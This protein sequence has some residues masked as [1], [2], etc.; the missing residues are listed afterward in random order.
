MVHI[1]LATEDEL[2]EEVA[3]ALAA[4]AGL[5]VGQTLRKRGFGYLQSNI[6]KFCELA[7]TFPV[8]LLTD[9][10]RRNCAPELVRT[11]IGRHHQP[12]NMLL[13][14][15]VREIESWLLAD[16][17]AMVELLG[18]K[19]VSHL[20]RE[21]DALPDPKRTLLQLAGFAARDVRADLIANA[22]AVASQGVGYNARL[23]ELVR[24]SWRATRAEQ[25]SPSLA[26]TRQRLLELADRLA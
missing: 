4:D 14:V 26:R 6:H 17:V 18:A 2:S 20:P 3:L 10:D 5:D 16:H 8:V 15:A 22:G 13:R 7:R 11:W 1:V 12:E 21:P 23:C 25:R 24:D 9:L 19:V